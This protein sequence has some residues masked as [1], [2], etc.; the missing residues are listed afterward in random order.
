M[1]MWQL[2][3]ISFLFSFICP[4]L[5]ARPLVPDDHEA[6]ATVWGQGMS[7]ERLYSET[8][9]APQ[10]VNLTLSNELPFERVAE[11]VS[12]GVS[13]ARGFVR[14]VRELALMNTRGT[15]VP[16]QVNTTGT[17]KDGTPRWILLTFF[18]Y[19]PA[20][21][22]A[23]YTLVRG[24]TPA[25]VETLTHSMHNGLVHIDTGCAR[26]QID[27]RRFRLFDSIKVDSQS[28]LA[29][30][31]TGGVV[32]EAQNG[33]KH[34][35]T[36]ATRVEIEQ[37]G[38]LALVLTVTGA[39][40]PGEPHALA[41]FVCRMT[42]Y[43][44][45]SEVRVFYTLHNPGAHRHP[46]NTWDLGTGGS[47]FM[48]DVSL[49]VPL[50][51]G[52]WASRLGVSRDDPPLR[53]E[54][55]YQ[56]SSGGPHWDSANH[57]DKDLKVP[58]NFRGYRVFQSGRRVHQGHRADAW[59]H[60]RR[61]SSGVT[62]AVRDFWQ[63][64]PKALSYTDNTLR[65]GLWPRESAGAHELLGG[66][67]KTHEMLFVFHGPQT[68]DRD[69]ARRM[70]SF[71][72]PLYAMPDP[73]T[74]YATR[75]FWPTG[76]LNR[77]EFTRLEQ[78]CDTF[79]YANGAQQKS[80]LTQ[81][82]RIDEYGWRHFGDSLA[83]NE[84]SPK[85]MML[86][87]PD[88]HVDGRPISHFGNEY[89]VN[90]GVLLQGLRRADPRWMWVADV[91]CRHYADIC[92]YHTDADGSKA[93]SHGPFT[94]TT[95]D[96]AALRSTHRM[97]P[98]E[99]DT[100]ELAYASGGPNAGHCYVASLAQHYYLTGNLTSRD[101]FL[102]VADW[103]VKSPWFTD[104]MMGDKRGIG[105]FLMTHVYAY[106]L[107]HDPQYYR[108]ALDMMECVQEP[109]SGLGATLFVKAAAR[110]IDM[111]IENREFDQDY[112]TAVNKML[113]F[114][115]LYLTLPLD[116]PRRWLEQAC[117]YAQLLY[118]CHL[119]APRNHTNQERYRM[120]AQTIMDETQSRWPGDYVA[121]KSLIMCFGNTGA[122]FR[123]L[124]L[125]ESV[126]PSNKTREK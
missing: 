77:Q 94:H 65:I 51:T 60:V 116:A 25:A 76:P 4:C 84:A 97:Y 115:D 71:H 88:H 43:A 110:F 126:M 42:F 6:V 103:T 2:Y 18:A 36:K 114:G 29:G 85:Q 125:H 118:T 8:Q 70:Q 31:K 64:F 38:P 92:I 75:A 5:C 54:T 3:S 55:L 68:G 53:A 113:M 19:L 89:D 28:L 50:G 37:Q 122:F 74:V 23:V 82:D 121:T 107:T 27:T 81:W 102:E 1:R 99:T 61:P 78:T 63:N 22:K 95:H 7:L 20:Q 73:E 15:A 120:Q 40:G 52:Q 35:E 26:F 30:D 9:Q 87:F 11:P 33:S 10:A 90:Y 86:D 109:F 91:K 93:Y 112:R 41:D 48:E 16:V 69:I 21:G 111:K 124:S 98:S 96:T 14:D 13:L 108:A 123:T 67:Q 46:G 62:V 66:E 80:M 44:G 72:A 57:V 119:Y 101:S 79:V 34:H 59:L 24:A 17:Y 56:D 49:L 104:K 39:F 32:L 105:N 47:V 58:L 45:K 100:Y 106:Q 117:F 12:C 83:D